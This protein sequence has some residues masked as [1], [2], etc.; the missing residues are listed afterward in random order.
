MFGESDTCSRSIEIDEPPGVE[1]K[2]SRMLL[3]VRPGTAQENMEAI[4]DAWYRKQ[5]KEA[6]LL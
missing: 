6:A 2:H 1:L 4:V 3:R 5:I